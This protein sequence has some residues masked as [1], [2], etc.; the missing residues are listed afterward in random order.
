[1]ADPRSGATEAEPELEGERM[2][3]ADRAARRDRLVGD[4]DRYSS[5]VRVLRAGREVPLRPRRRRGLAFFDDLAWHPIATR[6]LVLVV[7]VALVAV[8][9]KLGGDWLRERSVATWSGPDASVTSGQRLDACPDANALA[10][11]ETYPSWL[12]YDGRLYLRSDDVRPGM[13]DGISYV[14][15]GYRLDHLLLVLLQNTPDG[16]ARQEV[17]VWSDG[18]MAGYVY[19]VAPRC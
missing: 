4:R 14:D 15:T 18:A 6:L 1:M 19:R 17:M 16:L 2:S 5:L 13:V 9:A 12:R 10:S 8:G 7:V 3:I 11:V